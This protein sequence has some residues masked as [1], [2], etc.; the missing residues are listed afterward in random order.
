MAA[1]IGGTITACA[2]DDPFDFGGPRSCEVPDQNE[3]VLG[4]MQQAYLWSDDLPDVDP[5]AY[6]SPAAMVADLRV[7]HDRWSRVSDRAR[8]DAL[9]QEGKVLGLGFR[10]RRDADDR[11]VVATVDADTPAAA[12]GLVRGDVIDA[13]GGLTTAQIDEQSAWGDVYGESEPGVEVTLR[14]RAQ[15]GRARDMVLVKDWIS[16]DTVPETRVIQVDGR[17]VG[18]LAFATFVDTSIAALDDAFA[19]LRSAGVREVVVDLRYNG[20]GLIVVA[21]HFMHLLVGAVAEGSVAYRVRYNDHFAEENDDRVLMRLDQTLP[22]VDHVV[23]ITTGS[24]LSASELLINAVSA[25]V[26]VTIVGETTGGKPVG[27]R[28]FDFCDSQAAPVTFRLLNA[29]SEGDYYE[30]LPATC[31]APDDLWHPLGSEQEASLAAALHVL[32]TRRC[33]PLPEDGEG[34]VAPPPAGLRR[35]PATEAD[36]WPELGG[37]R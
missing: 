17:P 2:P 15:D 13:I 19:Q 28:H 33:L 3:W 23:F 30:G 5:L 11:V 35:R 36:A 27:S 32:A 6:D 18:Y 16:L 22:H 24:T 34:A 14:V 7:G 12:A 31:P 21:R 20:G 9:F 8:S 25:H 37:L 4:L 29:D 1:W 10:T 26:P